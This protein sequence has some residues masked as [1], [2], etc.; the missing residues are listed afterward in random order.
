MS[1]E[2]SLIREP[3][4]A[5][6]C[7]G[8]AISICYWKLTYFVFS[9]ILTRYFARLDALRKTEDFT[10]AEQGNQDKD[11]AIRYYDYDFTIFYKDAFGT[12]TCPPPPP[13]FFFPPASFDLVAHFINCS[14][15]QNAT[16]IKR[17]RKKQATPH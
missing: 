13:P 1:L 9:V 8:L 6:L 3:Y 11:P 17:S 16:R 4:M 14:R 5:L 15:R 10:F 12:P 2:S 7:I